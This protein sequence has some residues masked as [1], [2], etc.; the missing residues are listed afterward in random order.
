[1]VTDSKPVYSSENMKKFNLVL[2]EA[3]IDALDVSAVEK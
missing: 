2:P 3:Y 1:V